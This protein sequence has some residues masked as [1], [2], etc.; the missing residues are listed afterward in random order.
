[1]LKSKTEP[2]KSI[3][4]ID[5]HRIKEKHLGKSKTT[6]AKKQSNKQ[7]SKQKTPRLVCLEIFLALW[8]LRD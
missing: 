3:L 5:I 7:A 1:V 6:E 8:T 4:F 2:N